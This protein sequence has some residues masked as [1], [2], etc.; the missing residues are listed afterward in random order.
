MVLFFPC[1]QNYVITFDAYIVS[2]QK[3]TPRAEG[4]MIFLE[5]NVT[6]N[7]GINADE[8]KDKNSMKY[9]CC[10]KIITDGGETETTEDGKIMVRNAKSAVFIMSLATDYINDF[11]RFSDGSDPLRKATECV[12][13]AAEYGFAALYKRHLADYQPLY[14]RVS[15]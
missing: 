10:L 7:D 11:P 14:K 2:E 6:A 1:L 9:G 8:G 5:G 4:N 3:G 15:F 12:E 13:K